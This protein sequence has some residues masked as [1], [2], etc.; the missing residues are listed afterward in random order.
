MLADNSIWSGPIG[1]PLESYVARAYPELMPGSRDDQ[2]GETI[3]AA[4]VD[5]T[6]RE[7]TYPVTSDVQVQP[8]LLRDADGLR[9]Y[10]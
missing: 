1:T 6:L 3:I 2:E 4:I 9:I 8:V 10:R 5:G 7:L